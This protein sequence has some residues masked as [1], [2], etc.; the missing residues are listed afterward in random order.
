MTIVEKIT[1]D[2][3]RQSNRRMSF[4][5]TR[6]E[7]QTLVEDF[8]YFLCCKKAFFF[9]RYKM[10]ITSSLRCKL[11]NLPFLRTGGMRLGLKNRTTCARCFVALCRP[12]P[13]RQDTTRSNCGIRREKL[14]NLFANQRFILF[15]PFLYQ[16]Q[17]PFQ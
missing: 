12:N 17:I 7:H 2:K 8:E 9:C 1:I 13:L 15:V 10:K 6:L 4:Y 5:A 3:S 16:I 11:L 14:A